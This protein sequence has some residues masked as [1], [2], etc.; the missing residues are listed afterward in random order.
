MNLYFFNFYCDYSNSL[1]LS[2]TS[3]LWSSGAEF[4]STVSKFSKR[5][6]L[7]LLV[8]VSSKK[9]GNKH[10]HMV[11]VQSWQR[12]VKKMWCMCKVVV[13]PCLA[14]VCLMFLL[15][16]LLGHLKLRIIHDNLWLVKNRIFLLQGILL[17]RKWKVSRAP[18]T[19]VNYE[20]DKY[21]ETKAVVYELM[22][23]TEGMW[24]ADWAQ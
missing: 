24:F 8:Y 1:T 20:L 19:L 16:L 23:R 10:F 14:F 5:R 18:T 17:S 12:N 15:L 7:S 21:G 9:C 22:K 3:E 11:A 2:N 13:L 6:S 4:L